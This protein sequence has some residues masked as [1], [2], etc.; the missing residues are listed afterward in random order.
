MV[1]VSFQPAE[2]PRECGQCVEF[3]LLTAHFEENVM[4]E[5]RSGD[6]EVDLD[7]IKALLEDYHA[8]ALRLLAQVSL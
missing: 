5:L 8:D 6:S 7:E 2:A 3:R 4:N 1:T